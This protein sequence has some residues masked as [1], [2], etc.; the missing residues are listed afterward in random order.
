M[1]GTSCQ[2][3][4]RWGGCCI[5]A[6]LRDYARIGLFALAD[7]M[8]GGGAHVQREGWKRDF[9]PPS[10]AFPCYGYLSPRDAMR[11]NEHRQ[12]F[13]AALAAQLEAR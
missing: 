2:G 3:L 10:A 13:F 8:F 4:A 12:A 1:L 6:T 9:P 7:G 11:S 5:N